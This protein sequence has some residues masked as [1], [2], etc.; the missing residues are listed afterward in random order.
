MPDILGILAFCGGTVTI[1]IAALTAY[2][3]KVQADRRFVIFLGS[4]LLYTISVGLMVSTWETNVNSPFSLTLV[5][6]MCTA[7]M[8]YSESLSGT[9]WLKIPWKIMLVITVTAPVILFLFHEKDHAYLFS[10]F[11]RYLVSAVI[12]LAVFPLIRHGGRVDVERIPPRTYR[13]AGSLSLLFA[14]ILIVPT[15]FRGS[16]LGMERWNRIFY[17]SFYFLLQVRFSAYLLSRLLRKLGKSEVVRAESFKRF[18][19]SP[20]ETEVYDLAAKGYTY[21]EIARLL[22]ISLPTVKTHMDRPYKKT[23]SSN[24]VELIR[25]IDG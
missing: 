8:A 23:E 10:V 18:S 24:K 20:R 6:F 22:K 14:I 2:N 17:L 5:F 4:F 21:K 1:T 15:F 3:S 19:I 25:Q 7:L 12:L 11:V 13:T 9:G 16:I